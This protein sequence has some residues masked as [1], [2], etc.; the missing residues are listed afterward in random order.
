[1]RKKEKIDF[2]D[3][4]ELTDEQLRNARRVSPEMH[5]RL[6]RAYI[7]T[8]GKEPPVFRGRPPK[9]AHQLFKHVHMRMPPDILAR[10]KTKAKR[11]G[12]GYQTLINRVLTEHI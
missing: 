6:R 10:I 8:F 5:A 7:N 1:M 4:P 12:I 3:I 2:S 11:L 9:P